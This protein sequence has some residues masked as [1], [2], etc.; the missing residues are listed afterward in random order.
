MSLGHTDEA[1]AYYD[2]QNDWRAAMAAPRL[3]RDL[4]AQRE[5]AAALAA[6]LAPLARAPETRARVEAAA[7]AR[8]EARRD[9][10]DLLDL[11]LGAA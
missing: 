6:E 4:D 1:L 7:S 3:R 5:E 10:G 9:V 2:A 11:M 8:A